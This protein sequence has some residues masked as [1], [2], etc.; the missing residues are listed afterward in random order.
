MF[1]HLHDLFDLNN[2]HPYHVY[3][4]PANVY[5]KQHT[6]QIDQYN[7]NYQVP[8]K[9]HARSQTF[10]FISQINEQKLKYK[11]IKFHAVFVITY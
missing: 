7:E 9:H 8:T 11:L 1:T 2:A 4:H 10:N 6:T 3:V 5:T